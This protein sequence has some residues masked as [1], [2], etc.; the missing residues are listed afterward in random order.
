M[1][2]RFGPDCDLF[3]AFSVEEE[4]GIVITTALAE[5]LKG[6][7]FAINSAAGGGYRRSNGGA[8]FAYQAAEKCLWDL[9]VQR[10]QS[11]GHSSQMRA[12]NAAGR[13]RRA[14]ARA[15]SPYWLQSPRGVQWEIILAI[16]LRNIVS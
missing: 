16:M 12:D 5:R 2:L 10:P 9:R 7:H 3:I 13:Y 4:T 14:T 1:R 15:Q 11:R 8:T 6:A